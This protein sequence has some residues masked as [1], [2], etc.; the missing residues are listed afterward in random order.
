MIPIKV[1][2]NLNERLV[3]HLSLHVNR[4]VMSVL[5]ALFCSVTAPVTRS[6]ARLFLCQIRRFPC[7]VFGS[8]WPVSFFYQKKNETINYFFQ[9]EIHWLWLIFYEEHQSKPIFNDFT[10]YTH[11]THLYYILGVW[12]HW[13][14]TPISTKTKTS[15]P[16]AASSRTRTSTSD[17]LRS[18]WIAMTQ[19]EGWTT[20]KT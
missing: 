2:G 5:F 11:P 15:S 12:V 20:W 17:S 16:S 9:P 7:M 13:T 1:M 19:K 14:S 3:C 8:M 18:S 4:V 10:L 6:T